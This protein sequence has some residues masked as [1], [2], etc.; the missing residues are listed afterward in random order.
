MDFQHSIDQRLP[1]TL[2]GDPARLRQIAINLLSNAFKF[3]D[4]GFVQ[5]EVR[6]H[7][8]NV[9]KLIVSDS[10]I[11]IPSHMQE[12]I[13]DEFRQADSTS[14][15]E[16]GGTGLGLAIVRK[17]SMMMGGNVRV[18]SKVGQG[19]VFTVFL[20]LTTEVEDAS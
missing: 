3:T 9:W 8:K 10:G 15:R 14:Q 2:I 4:Q 1:M 19:S 7:N 12:T 5:I 18:N 6:Q 11:G 16:H 13:F 17:L 20:P